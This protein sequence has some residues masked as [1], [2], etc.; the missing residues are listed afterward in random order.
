M[1][2]HTLF[3]LS[4]A[5]VPAQPQT[6]GVKSGLKLGASYLGLSLLLSLAL[7]LVVL[8]YGTRPSDATLLY[9]GVL[10]GLTVISTL[11]LLRFV[12]LGAALLLPVL[13]LSVLLGAL[14]HNAAGLILSLGGVIFALGGVQ[15]S[16]A[17]MICVVTMQIAAGLLGL[18]AGGP[19][20][21]MLMIPVLAIN[22]MRFTRHEQQ[23]RRPA[24]AAG[25]SLLGFAV[26]LLGARGVFWGA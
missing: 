22:V 13:M 15:R 9:R 19:Q 5:P 26:T 12:R 2:R 20:L 8:G 1:D 11:A 4:L 14:T 7:T 21:I 6:S 17:L 3:L 23:L 24:V 10:I 25:L 18:S 16:W